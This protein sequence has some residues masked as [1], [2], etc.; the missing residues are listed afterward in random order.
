VD[1]NDLQAVFGGASKKQHRFVLIE[2]TSHGIGYNPPA[3]RTVTEE[4]VST[5][6]DFKTNQ[7]SHIGFRDIV[8]IATRERRWATENY[9]SMAVEV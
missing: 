2:G 7:L 3:L 4:I 1:P 5:I 8:D 6:T 9:Q